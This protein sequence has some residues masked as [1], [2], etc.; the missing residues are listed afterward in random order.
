[1]P[2]I[3]SFKEDSTKIKIP[4]IRLAKIIERQ[5]GDKIFNYELRYSDSEKLSEEGLISLEVLLSKYMKKNIEECLDDMND[6]L[7]EI[8]LLELHSTSCR[9]GIS[10]MIISDKDINIQGIKRLWLMAS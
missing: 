9:T 5:S 2:L 4:G 6:D 8:D 7:L 1:M 3:D 10:L